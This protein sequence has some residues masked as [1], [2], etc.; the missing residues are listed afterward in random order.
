MNIVKAIR[1]KKV[2][3]ALPMFRDLSTWTNWLI[4]LKAIF[5]LPLSGDELEV[6]Q[7]FTGRKSA[8]SEP[9]KEVFLIIGRR[10]G[11]S[12]ISA[13]IAVF[14]AAFRKWNFDIGDGYI[15]SLAVDR[16]QAG[17]VFGYIRDILR[18]PVFKGLV[19]TELKE[20]IELINRVVLAVH[21]CSYRALRGYRIL[22]AVCD[23]AAFWR[24][25]GVNPSG[26]VLTALRPALGE[27]PESLLLAIS[28]PYSKTGPLYETFRDKYGKD[29]PAVLVWKAGTLDMNPTYSKKVIARAEAEDP[30]AAASE[31]AA[32]F[33]ADLE[34]YLSIEAI[35]ACV[36]P[37]RFELPKIKDVSYF[38][39]V[40]PSGGRGDSM[41][42]SLAHKE[43]ERI[44]QD[45]VRV[46]RPPFDPGA[47]V[48]EFSE[49]LKNYGVREVTG[50]KYSGEWCSST[51]EKKGIRYKNAELSK[52]D[53]YIE[54]LPLIMQRRIELLDSKQ[55]TIELRQLERRTGR[56]KDNVDHPRGLH[57]DAAN[58]CAG[59]ITLAAKKKREARLRF[60]T[61]AETQAEKA[62]AVE[63]ERR[64]AEIDRE[65]DKE[66]EER[67]KQEKDDHL[68]R[69]GWRRFL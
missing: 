49:A 40:D 43:G 36:V 68:Q 55:Q 2:F 52:S 12:F 10:G 57:D 20:E 28:T 64:D 23:E 56:G 5:G 39:F 18:L 59:V 1:S 30:Q 58:A 54:F 24:V 42:L 33:R 61:D 16:E 29:D 14:L 47:C 67:G 62:E 19:K 60:L 17:V 27:N 34:T 4:C 69:F 63:D 46:K 13:L 3:G 51:F 21:T 25:E 32:E 50:D 53:I 41:T 66:D 26:E 37:G 6:Y 9:F 8:P 45:A 44:V 48:K 7:K 11:K 38:A 35:E 65:L 22:A 31:Y 15:V